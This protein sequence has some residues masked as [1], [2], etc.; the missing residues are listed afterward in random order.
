MYSLH[1]L[2]RL[3]CLNRL[4]AAT[5]ATA[6]QEVFAPVT[7]SI[8]DAEHQAAAREARTAAAQAPTAATQ[9]A[10]P[11]AAKTARVERLPD[12]LS[13]RRGAGQAA[14]SRVGSTK[15]LQTDELG[16]SRIV[17]L[18]VCAML[19]DRSGGT[20]VQSYDV[21]GLVTN[22]DVVENSTEKQVFWVNVLV[23]DPALP[24]ERFDGGLRMEIHMWP[25]LEV[26]DVRSQVEAGCLVATHC[27]YV[28]EN[29]LPVF[30]DRLVTKSWGADLQALETYTVT[31]LQLQGLLSENS[32]RLLRA[33]QERIHV[34]PTM[35]GWYNKPAEGVS[36]ARKVAHAGTRSKTREQREVDHDVWQKE[37]LTGKR[38]QAQLPAHIHKPLMVSW[39]QSIRKCTYSFLLFFFLAADSNLF[40]PAS[41]RLFG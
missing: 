23:K 17:S 37:D 41:T 15:R 35:L 29:L 30:W 7:Q 26:N 11:A 6:V 38:Q 22:E 27:F 9:P 39:Q 32:Y 18:R 19:N 13:G 33:K 8:A 36:S 28:N 40:M 21:L 4:T 34:D 3:L 25:L 10:R 20:S 12:T 2:R 1:G 14:D 16:T 5:I 31:N 24:G